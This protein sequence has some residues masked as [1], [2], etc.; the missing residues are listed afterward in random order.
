MLSQVAYNNKGLSALHHSC[1][2]RKEEARFSRQEEITRLLIN[3]GAII[4]A[5]NKDGVTPLMGASSAGNDKLLFP[6]QHPAFEKVFDTDEIT[7]SVD[8]GDLIYTRLAQR[9]TQNRLEE[10]PEPP[11]GTP[12]GTPFNGLKT[13][14]LQWL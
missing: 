14:T 5:V 3:G 13:E 8:Q 9:N 11:R 12:R 2:L 4:D 1:F 7:E 6:R 10:H